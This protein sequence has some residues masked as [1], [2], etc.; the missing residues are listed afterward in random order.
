[1]PVSIPNPRSSRKAR[2]EIIPLIDIMFFLLATFV[3][4]SISMVKNL[5][6]PVR[7]PVAATGGAQERQD[8]ASI[9]VREDGTLYF[10]KEPL[11]MSE[12]PSRLTT[13]KRSAPEP[14]LFISGDAR[15][16]FQSVVTVLDEARRAGLTR[17]AI[18]TNRPSGAP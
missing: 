13:F 9:T 15:A 18:E 2:I 14:R 7:L 16:S 12:L 8:A 10:N 4:V 17:I 3:M 6:L 1:M 11:L 5:A